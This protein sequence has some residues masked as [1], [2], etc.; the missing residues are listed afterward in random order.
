[1]LAVVQGILLLVGM[2]ISA[3]GAV[4]QFRAYEHDKPA[5]CPLA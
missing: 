5:T 4:L 2:A 3:H 1:M